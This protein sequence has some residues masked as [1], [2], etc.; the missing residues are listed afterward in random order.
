MADKGWYVVTHN[1]VG[2]WVQ[3]QVIPA[4]ALVDADNIERLVGIGAI[5]KAEDEEIKVAKDNPEAQVPVLGLADLPR[6][7]PPKEYIATALP[8]GEAEAAQAARDEVNASIVE[9]GNEAQA[10]L[11]KHAEILRGIE[12]RATQSALGAS[13]DTAVSEADAAAGQ[14][15]RA[16]AKN[17]AKYD[18]GG[19]RPGGD[20][21]GTSKG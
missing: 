16:A 7:Q 11:D 8:P 21:E 5:R 20:S 1:A 4:D 6:A 17:P 18:R 12:E 19:S 10:A 2:R 14:G 15:A 9:S 3:G 13:D